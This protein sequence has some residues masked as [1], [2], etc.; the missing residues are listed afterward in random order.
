MTRKKK[1]PGGNLGSTGGS[2]SAAD[3]TQCTTAGRA[4]S[5]PIFVSGKVVGQVDGEVFR[6]SIRGSVH[7]LRRPRAIAFDVS[8]LRDAE[9]AGAR[10]VV[11]HD[12]DSGHY[13][14]APMSTVWAKG[15]RVSRGYGDQWALRVERFDED[16]QPKQLGLFG[17]AR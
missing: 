5:I 15:F 2:V 11:V 16:E 10:F 14:H 9:A 4:A 8:T 6:K 12:S 3:T 17:G 13:Y 1:S 7:M